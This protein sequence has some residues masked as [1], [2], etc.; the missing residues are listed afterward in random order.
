M[1][2]LI[3]V[4][5]HRSIKAGDVAQLNQSLKNKILE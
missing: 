3:S 2:P 1:F 4:D 5:Q